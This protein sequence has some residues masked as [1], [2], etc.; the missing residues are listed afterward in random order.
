ML[1]DEKIVKYFFFSFHTKIPLWGGVKNWS[2]LLTDSTKKLPTWGNWGCQKSGTIT[3]LIYGWSLI[4]MSLTW[5]GFSFSSMSF[6]HLSSGSSFR[7]NL[8]STKPVWTRGNYGPSP[9]PDLSRYRSKN[10]I[11]SSTAG[12]LAPQILGPSAASVK[13]YSCCSTLS[14]LQIMGADIS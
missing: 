14:F 3:D 8:G 2:K 1:K 10:K 6:T 13:L 11:L 12:P 7:S 4:V 9:P 5:H